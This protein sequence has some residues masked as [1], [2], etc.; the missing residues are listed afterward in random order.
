MFEESRRRSRSLDFERCKAWLNDDLPLAQ[1]SPPSAP[2][3]DVVIKENLWAITFAINEAEKRIQRYLHSYVDYAPQKT[4]SDR[5]SAVHTINRCIRACNMSLLYPKSRTT[6]RL[7][8]TEGHSHGRFRL[9]ELNDHNEPTGRHLL[10]D[11]LAD[12]KLA[13]SLRG[14]MLSS[15]SSRTPR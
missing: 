11:D 1:S 14:R 5:L 10:T 7:S 15:R 3:L 9:D 8:L 12:L 13:C 4:R 6:C 2:L